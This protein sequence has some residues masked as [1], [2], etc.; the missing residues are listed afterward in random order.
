MNGIRTFDD[1]RDRSVI[2]DATGCWLYGGAKSAD[3]GRPVLWHPD[4]RKTVSLGTF[5]SLVLFGERPPKGY[6]W[7]PKCEVA[8]CC[9]PKHQHLVPKTRPGPISAERRARLTRIHR[10]RATRCNV[11]IA[12]AI[13]T[14][15]ETG[16][17]LAD[18][19]AISAQMV[20]LIRRHEAWAPVSPWSMP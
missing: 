16:A 9:N 5:L 1:L 12:A 13:R 19:F 14:S 20:S 7:H 10:E 15:E 6:E 8:A 17:V 11:E 4:L 2:D 3:G 18:R